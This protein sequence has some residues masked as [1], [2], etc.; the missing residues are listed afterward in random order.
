L[1]NSSSAREIKILM[2]KDMLS[3]NGS[4]AEIWDL[5]KLPLPVNPAV[6]TSGINHE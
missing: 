4:Y 1:S 6:I 2:L 5:Q 3:P